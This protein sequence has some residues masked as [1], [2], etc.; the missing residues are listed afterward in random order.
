MEIKEVEKLLSVSRSNIR[1]YEKEGLIAP[2]R[3]NNNYRKYS[4]ADVAMLKKIIILRK[5]GFSVEEISAMQKGD[6]QLPDAVK[7]NIKRLECEIEKLKG[8]LETAKV[9][10]SEQ[11]TFEDMDE[12]YY[13]DMTIQAENN[14]KEFTD[15]C[16]DCL[17]F[18]LYL[19]DNMWKYV[20]FHDFKK[21]RKKYGT[22]IA[23]CILLLICI[24]R[25]ISRAVIWHESFWDGFLYPITVF[26]I[27]A[28]ILLPIYLLSKKLPKA[29]KVIYT[30]I[31]ILGSGFILFCICLL[32][33]ALIMSIIN[34]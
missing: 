13:W 30:I 7:E 11:V 17:M 22:A 27:A 1:F 4:E 31:A 32:L 9:L 23:C 20:F 16:K 14:G 6:L 5:L 26:L 2:E 15:I 3:G 24:I 10:S 8:A 25:G 19:F 34:R 28:A 29:A 12:E 18:N 33:Y 21:S